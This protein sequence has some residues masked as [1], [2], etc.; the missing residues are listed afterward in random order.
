MKRILFVAVAML[1]C[2]AAS[3][4]VKGD[5]YAGLSMGA[6]VQSTSKTIGGSNSV[7]LAAQ[8]EIGLFLAD[9]LRLGIGVGGGLQKSGENTTVSFVV[10]PALAY[11]FK[12]GERSYY[13]PEIGF[14]WESGN[15]LESVPY[16]GWS[17]YVD[18]LSFE[19]R[20]SDSMAMAFSMGRMSTVW[21][22]V[23]GTTGNQFSLMLNNG[24]LGLR[25][26]L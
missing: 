24:S 25:Y 14:S 16:N 8:T 7:S 20:I 9:N 12:L 19:F 15:A 4:Q 13:T 1:F 23:L 10:N 6:A 18:F 22:N 3:A 17:M 26:Y 21:L 2:L 11:Y 5:K